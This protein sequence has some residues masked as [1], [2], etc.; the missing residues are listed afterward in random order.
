MVRKYQIINVSSALEATLVS[1]Y[2]N[3][4]RK[5]SILHWAETLGAHQ[6]A[7]ID[8]KVTTSKQLQLI[9]LRPSNGRQLGEL[10]V[11]LSI[12]VGHW[13]SGER[14]NSH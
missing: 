3:T 14:R 1:T 8:Q 10:S 12:L 6:Y 11:K 9:V 2:F 13:R 7:P 4:L 5:T